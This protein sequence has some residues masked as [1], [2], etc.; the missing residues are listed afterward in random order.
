MK[1]LIY[2]I[3]L[4]LLYIQC[5]AQKPIA[6]GEVKGKQTTF[7]VNELKPFNSEKNIIIYSKNNK[8]NN[9]VP[10]PKNPSLPPLPLRY[11]T[12]NKADVKP[13][14]YDILKQKID[15]LQRNKETIAVHVLFKT[16]GEVADISFTLH[17]NTLITIQEIEEIDKQLRSKIKASFT[18]KQYFEYEVISGGNFP[19]I[20]FDIN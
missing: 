11:V 19:V 8:Y 20:R 9:G 6:L 12:V 4:C 18:G 15:L 3:P 7:V 1:N 16:T 5:S 17:E 10:Y 13:I 2:C 14:V